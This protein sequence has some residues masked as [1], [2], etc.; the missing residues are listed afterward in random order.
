MLL[1]NGFHA[2]SSRGTTMDQ[3]AVQRFGE[4]KFVDEVWLR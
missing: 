3:N 2:N 4:I 1:W